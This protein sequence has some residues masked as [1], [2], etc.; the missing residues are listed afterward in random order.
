MLVPLCTDLYRDREEHMQEPE[1]VPYLNCD[2]ALRQQSG[3]GGKGQKGGL[4]WVIS[5]LCISFKVS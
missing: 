4:L 1:Y 5:I 3:G 2:L